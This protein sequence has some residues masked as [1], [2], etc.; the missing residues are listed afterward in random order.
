MPCCIKA[1]LSPLF[2]QPHVV[3]GQ[4]RDALELGISLSWVCTAQDGTRLL[5]LCSPG[6][7]V[8]AGGGLPFSGDGAA[9]AASLARQ[10]GGAGCWAWDWCSW[11]PRHQTAAAPA[12]GAAVT[13]MACHLQALLTDGRWA[14]LMKTNTRHN[15]GSSGTVPGALPGWECRA[16]T[17]RL[18]PGQ[19]GM[20]TLATGAGKPHPHTIP[21]EAWS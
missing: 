16:Q 13:A 14:A 17:G 21:S 15:S 4:L 5:C 7:W 18:L 1:G 2:S 8:L 20:G 19:P 3:M 9:P 11:A 10:R 6:G 12:Q